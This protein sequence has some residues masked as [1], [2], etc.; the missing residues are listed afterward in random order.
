MTKIKVL[1]EGYAK[2][3]ENG[4]LASSTTVL[5]KDKGESQKN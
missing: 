5:I 1:I 4:W 2:Q 3:T